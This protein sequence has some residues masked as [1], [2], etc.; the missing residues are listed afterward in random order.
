MH[1][2]HVFT[3]RNRSSAGILERLFIRKS[4]KVCFKESTRDRH[5]WLG[6]VLN[7]NPDGYT[8]HKKIR[9]GA[10]GHHILLPGNQ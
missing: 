10:A 1:A 5:P 4:Q 9:S 6:S 8:V 7:P 2:G 3:D